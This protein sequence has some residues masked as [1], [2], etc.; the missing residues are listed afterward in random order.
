MTYPNLDQACCQA[1]EDVLA[2]IYPEAAPQWLACA[3]KYRL[4]LGK[5]NLSPNVK[6]TCEVMLAEAEHR[7]SEN[8]T[9]KHVG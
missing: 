6:T 1:V 7:L 4:S 9:S 3:A 8:S 2:R 5:E